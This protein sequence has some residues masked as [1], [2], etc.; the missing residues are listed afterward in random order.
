[1]S[2]KLNTLQDQKEMYAKFVEKNQLIH[3][4][5]DFESYYRLL[6]ANQKPK[7]WY[8]TAALRPN[9]EGFLNNLL[10]WNAEKKA[11]K[12][13]AED[14]K[15]FEEVLDSLQ[16]EENSALKKL[17]RTALLDLYDTMAGDLDKGIDSNK[18]YLDQAIALTE[19]YDRIL[20]PQDKAKMKGAFKD[21]EAGSFLMNTDHEMNGNFSSTLRVL[22]DKYRDPNQ[23]DAEKAKWNMLCNSYAVRPYMHA[24]SAKVKQEEKQRAFEALPKA[25]QERINAL[26]A[27]AERLKQN[28]EE[29]LN[30]SPAERNQIRQAAVPGKLEEKQQKQ[31]K[32][33]TELKEAQ[34]RT[35]D[36]NGWTHR[37][38]VEKSERLVRTTADLQLSTKDSV[39]FRQ[40]Y[41]SLTKLRNTE[42]FQSMD[43]LLAEGKG[44]EL[45]QNLN[46]AM[47]DTQAY[48]DYASQKS[49]MQMG[50]LGRKRLNAARETLNELTGISRAIQE[51]AGNL[52]NFR[53]RKEKLEK[54]EKLEDVK[55]Q[56][57]TKSV[58]VAET[59]AKM[60]T[61]RRKLN[62]V[63]L[64]N[65]VNGK[66]AVVTEKDD[67]SSWVVVDYEKKAD[68]GMSK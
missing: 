61:E 11:G 1:M 7:T 62:M 4:I 10:S 40:M 5:D 32:E 28:P 35:N 13:S 58:S 48:I 56:V 15:G 68:K 24:I 39:H 57:E 25:E 43:K 49:F 26:K 12:L 63:D 17:M 46:Q 2:K 31:Q 30:L 54:L 23:T 21:G 66:K 64:D 19:L 27:E 67:L 6:Q 51:E 20:N 59:A 37:M 47:G 50:M 9:V 42:G 38:F 18:H 34:R 55:K 14:E 36:H 8:M 29:F 53:N 45:I 22:Y 65:K 52:Q 3:M 41:D 33:I 60:E 16:Q 44:E